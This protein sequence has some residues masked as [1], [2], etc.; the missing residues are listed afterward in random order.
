[1]KPK[2]YNGMFSKFP[3][4]ANL[5][6]Q[7]FERQLI[8]IAVYRQ[9]GTEISILRAQKG[10]IVIVNNINGVSPPGEEPNGRNFAMSTLFKKN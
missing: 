8:H 6:G 7:K 2:S 10:V 1:M 3:R 5:F 9:M 4:L